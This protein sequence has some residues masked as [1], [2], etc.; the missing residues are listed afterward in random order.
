M[1]VEKRAFV[2][3]P[4]LDTTVARDPGDKQSYLVGQRYGLLTT[5]GEPVIF[6]T[7]SRRKS[8]GIPVRCDCG[9]ETIIAVADLVRGASRSC[10]CLKHGKRQVVKGDVFGRW[11]VVGARL[12]DGRTKVPCRCA[13]GTERIVS[14]ASLLSGKSTSCGCVSR[15]P[16]RDIQPGDTFGLWTVRGDA[17]RKKVGPR[18]RQFFECECFCGSIRDVLKSALL[19]GQ[20]SSCGCT[21][22][23]GALRQMH[24]LSRDGEN[25]SRLYRIWATLQSARLLSPEWED[26][27]ASFFNWA[28]ETEYRDD[29]LLRRLNSGELFNSSNC[30]WVLSGRLGG[31]RQSSRRLIL[32]RYFDDKLRTAAY[33]TMG[34][35]ILA[36]FGSAIFGQRDQAAHTQTVA[37]YVRRLQPLQ[38]ELEDVHHNLVQLSKGVPVAESI[39]H[40]EF[41]ANEQSEELREIR[42]VPSE[43][44]GTHDQLLALARVLQDGVQLAKSSPNEAVRRQLADKVEKAE[45]MF[46]QIGAKLQEANFPRVVERDAD[47][48]LIASSVLR[49]DV[50]VF[51]D[52]R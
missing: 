3:Q 10:G 51:M 43:L 49:G 50:A 39:S 32:Y 44:A 12:S 23:T 47:E 1:Q 19:S 5:V 18:S 7:K 11:T 9:N 33:L 29:L 4:L 34:I 2:P 17:G 21:A 37:E 36:A 16:Q 42:D 48:R 40:I 20:S 46:K 6:L 26:N 28:K 15:T 25:K 45:Q 14:T 41:D 38:R 13:C 27:F 22:G 8:K 35:A 24:G 31:K 30:E 52:R